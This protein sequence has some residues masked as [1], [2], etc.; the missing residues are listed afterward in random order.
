MHRQ[1]RALREVHPECIRKGGPRPARALE[2][3]PRA[4][5]L[6][7]YSSSLLPYSCSLQPYS[8][9]L[10]P[11]SSSLQP[12][13]SSLQPCSSSLQPCSSSLQPCSSSLQP[14]L[15]PRRNLTRAVFV[16]VA[17]APVIKRSCPVKGA[18]AFYLYYEL[19]FA[20]VFPLQMNI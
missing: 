12:R 3:R 16:A 10:Q 19:Q 7:P 13:S 6:Q 15:V 11:C 2:T 20:A 18:R 8:S 14:D 17:R 1:P 5:A 4:P 9:S